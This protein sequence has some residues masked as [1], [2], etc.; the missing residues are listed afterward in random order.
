VGFCLIFSVFSFSRRC[1]ASISAIFVGVCLIFSVFSFCRRCLASI[2]AIFV[3]ICH[4]HCFSAFNYFVHLY[5]WV[6]TDVNS[7]LARWRRTA[8]EFLFGPEADAGAAPDKSHLSPAAVSCSNVISFKERVVNLH[9]SDVSD[10][11]TSFEEQVGA[12]NSEV[13]NW[14]HAVDQDWWGSS[15]LSCK[16][17][18]DKIT[19]ASASTIIGIYSH[20]GKCA[21]KHSVSIRFQCEHGRGRTDGG[22]KSREKSL[23]K[24]LATVNVHAA[25]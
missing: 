17:V 9:V 11:P 16:E 24:D 20:H 4:S 5:L 22:E 13:L 1:L 15:A 3:G 7:F 2:S 8:S 23:S 25:G 6:M 12:Y 10:L 19:G 21:S 14:T 18:Q